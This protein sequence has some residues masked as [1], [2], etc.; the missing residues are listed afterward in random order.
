V[1]HDFRNHF[2]TNFG[3]ADGVALATRGFDE[4]GPLRRKRL[5]LPAD[6]LDEGTD[7]AVELVVQIAL[8]HTLGES[9]S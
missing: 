5:L 7:D 1:R 2:A 3:A 8:N 4:Q 9:R 6:Q